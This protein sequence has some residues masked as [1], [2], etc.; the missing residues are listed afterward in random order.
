MLNR[1]RVS[2]FR[3]IGAP[4]DVALGPFVAL[5]GPNG[6]GKSS[7]VDA[8]RL[9]ADATRLGLPAALDAQGGFARVRHVAAEDAG[10]ASI[11]GEGSFE[12][13]LELSGGPICSPSSPG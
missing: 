10:G 9:V 5:V 4:V 7:L 13:A 2:G 11:R 3:G 8:L 6:A 1:I 12:I